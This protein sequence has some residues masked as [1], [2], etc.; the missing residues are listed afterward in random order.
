MLGAFRRARVTDFRAE[1]AN[2]GNVP[3]APRH[4]SSGELADGCT[5]RIQGYT[6]RHHFY[7]VFLQ[8]SRTAVM[9]R[10]HAVVARLYTGL[11]LF[12]AHGISFDVPPWGG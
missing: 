9:A 3:T 1:P 8:A 6:G 10:G 11:E 4:R 2:S 7:V 5:V 12:M